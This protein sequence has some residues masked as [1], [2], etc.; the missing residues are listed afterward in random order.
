M[1]WIYREDKMKT[2]VRY[3]VFETNSSSMHSLVLGGEQKRSA[4]DIPIYARNR[5]HVHIILGGEYDGRSIRKVVTQYEKLNYIID[6]LFTKNYSDMETLLDSEDYKNVEK[7]VC[8]YTGADHFQ[9]KLFDAWTS[10]EDEG[11]EDHPYKYDVSFDSEFHPLYEDCL[12][13][14][15]DKDKLL[16]FI[17][18]DRNWIEIAFN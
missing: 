13:D 14:Y 2:V 16:D 1:A 9:T 15:R 6:W 17:F 11:Y 8:E 4:P 12:V 18:V 7:W 5:D 3:G 10:E